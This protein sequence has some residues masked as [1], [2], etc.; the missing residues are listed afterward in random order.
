[1]RWS[2]R[3][4]L[5]PAPMGRNPQRRSNYPTNDGLNFAG[6]DFPTPV[7]QIDR[8]ERQNPNLALNVFGWEKEQVIVHRISEKDGSM[9]RINV[10]ITKKGEN[11]HCSLVKRLTAG[12]MAKAR[13]LTA[14]ISANA[15]CTATQGKTSLK[16][17]SPS[18]KGCLKVQQ[19]QRCL[20][21]GETRCLSQITTSR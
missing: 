8:L 6:I 20:K 3:A 1:M 9:P 16:G 13:T 4:A 17:T 12:C 2:I 19:E 11:T 7:S 18:A 5:F 15:A 14:N 21:R 10:M